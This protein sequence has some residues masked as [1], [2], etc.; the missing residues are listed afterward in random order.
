M[1]LS[2]DTF[3]LIN[4]LYIFFVKLSYLWSFLKYVLE[5]YDNYIQMVTVRMQK[6]ILIETFGEF[7][8][9]NFIW[10]LIDCE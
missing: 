2:I 1:N 7:F 4:I 5:I 9:P 3:C 10:A 8:H 6:F